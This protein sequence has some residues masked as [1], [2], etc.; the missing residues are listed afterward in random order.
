ME[1]F[2]F[3]HTTM[4]Y[5]LDFKIQHL[6][7]NYSAYIKGGGCRCLKLSCIPFFFCFKGPTRF[8]TVFAQ[9]KV[10]PLKLKVKSHHGGRAT[11]PT[12]AQVRLSPFSSQPSQ[13]QRDEA[14]HSV[15]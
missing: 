6:I 13:A 9:C 14:L 2:L 4:Q 1:P 5:A 11:S 3:H 8:I 15:T 7:L 12:L 10:H